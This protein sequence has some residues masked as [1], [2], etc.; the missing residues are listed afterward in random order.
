MSYNNFTLAQRNLSAY[1][2]GQFTNKIVGLAYVK[3]FISNLCKSCGLS[4]STTKRVINE[5]ENN[6]AK[7]VRYHIIEQFFPTHL[8]PRNPNRVPYELM[9]YNKIK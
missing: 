4:E 2:S 6:E 8:K 7:D 3:T 9:N 1:R 5:I